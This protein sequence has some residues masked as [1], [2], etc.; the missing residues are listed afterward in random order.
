MVPH[1]VPA[2]SEP[3]VAKL[4][5]AVAKVSS[6]KSPTML[7]KSSFPDYESPPVNEVVIGMVYQ[8]LVSMRVVH[9]G[10]IWEKIRAEFPLIEHA[11]PLGLEELFKGSLLSGTGWPSTLLPRVWY[12]NQKQDKL[13]QL[14]HDRFY[15]NWRSRSDGEP[16]PRYPTMLRMYEE[17]MAVIA[18]VFRQEGVGDIVP[19]AY[20]LR[21]INHI[22]KGEAWERF[23]DIEKIFP[24]LAWRNDPKRFLPTPIGGVWSAA[25][26]L[27]NGMGRLNVRA[28]PGVRTVK[29]GKQQILILELST[30]GPAASVQSGMAKEWFDVAHE[31]IVRGF[32]DLTTL[33]AQTNLWKR[34]DGNH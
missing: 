27:P 11:P 15:V 13:L 24:D 32:A 25:F 7:L 26:A 12:I 34:K 22:L 28:Q 16:Y 3:A 21:Y 23:E 19:A 20:E 30:G 8:P 9:Y 17:K 14:Q 2:Q 6:G 4:E 29:E 10:L 31:W 33:D 5:S 1:R 18:D